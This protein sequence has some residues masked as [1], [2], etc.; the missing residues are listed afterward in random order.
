MSDNFPAR[1]R[2]FQHKAKSLED[3]FQL[4]QKFIDSGKQL[5][6][7]APESDVSLRQVAELTGYAPS[8][9]YKYFPTK[10]DL[11]Y[12][13]KEEFLQLS[14]Q[15]AKRRI[16]TETDPAKRL[17]LGFEAMVEFWVLTPG[18]FRCVYSYRDK[19]SPT[20]IRLAPLLADS[21]IT[22]AARAFSESLVAEFFRHHGVVPDAELLRLLTDA[23]VVA[24]HGVVSIP[25]GSPSFSYCPPEEMARTVVRG[26]VRSWASY[27]D[28][29]RIH[30]LPK[31]PTAAHFKSYCETQIFK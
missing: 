23:I 25:L 1:S 20:A 6:S 29:L 28:F 13:I 7:R 5:I 27:V 2:K 17:S 11:V 15:H 22:I 12:A 19:P 9:I 3:Q 18:Q 24:S 4:R 16:E 26:I 31:Y 10:V 30:K 21:S 8:A 14:V